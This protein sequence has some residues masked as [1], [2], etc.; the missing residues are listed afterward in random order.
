MSGIP[1]TD[2]VPNFT[3]ILALDLN[4]FFD[5]A[6]R[7][8]RSEYGAVVMSA[9]FNNIVRLMVAQEFVK[10]LKRSA[11]MV[12]YPILEF[13]LQL[14]TLPAPQRGVSEQVI[15]ELA[16]IVFPERAAAGMLTVQDRSDLIHLAI[17][18]HHKIAA[19]VTAYCAES[20]SW[21][22]PE[23]QDLTF[24]FARLFT[25]CRQSLLSPACRS[26]P[27]SSRSTAPRGP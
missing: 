7:R 21:R 3:T 9:A 2:P 1:L 6:R 15:D 26:S 20:C 12:Q 4:V 5:I 16:A 14:P 24:G 11:S 13:A 17:A 22:L 10:E 27:L 25:S 18:A 8:P 23:R 19:F